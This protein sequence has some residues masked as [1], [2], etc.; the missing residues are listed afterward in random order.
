VTGFPQD[1]TNETRVDR[2][3][4]SL[5][6]ERDARLSDAMMS[7]EEVSQAGASSYYAVEASGTFVE[8]GTFTASGTCRA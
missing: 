5:E 7:V 4:V 8:G 3:Q 2:F 6:G 1:E